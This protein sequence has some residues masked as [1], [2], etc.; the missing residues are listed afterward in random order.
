MDLKSYIELRDQV[1]SAYVVKVI[2]SHNT[3]LNS[4]LEMGL[5]GTILY[6]YFFVLAFKYSFSYKHREF[7]EKF[8]QYIDGFQLSFM[9]LII[10]FNFE[11]YFSVYDNSSLVIWLLISL[12]FLFY[13]FSSKQVKDL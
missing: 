6:F 13:N 1:Y 3:Y 8:K 12:S 2:H 5:V 9:G 4:L 7:R 11:P 10:I